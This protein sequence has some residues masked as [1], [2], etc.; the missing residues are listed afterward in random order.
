MREQKKRLFDF[1]FPGRPWIAAFFALLLSFVFSLAAAEPAERKEELLQPENL[2]FGVPKE[3]D[4]ILHREGFS[5]GYSHKYRQALW[6]GYV[7]KKEH[8]TG[9]R[10]RRPAAFR[11]DPAITRDPVQPG[12]YTGTKF[13]RGHLAPAGDMSYSHPA[14]LNSF[15]MSNISPQTPGCNRG[16]WKRLET[17]IRKWAVSEECLC[18]ITG[19]LFPQEEDAE[20]KDEEEGSISLPVPYAF[21]KVVLDM[22]PPMKMIA[23]IVPNRAGRERLQRFV[24]TVDDVEKLTGCDFFSEL[25]DALEDKLERHSDFSQWQEPSPARER[26]QSAPPRAFPLEKEA[27]RE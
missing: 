3:T 12:E 21:Y 25:D 14:I 22:T 26:K 1:S 19:P 13:D 27:L 6:V 16:I 5:L 4:R 9:K 17:Q 10:F 20:G 11:S 8:L 15:F 7:L 18:V 23:F 2:P 24:V